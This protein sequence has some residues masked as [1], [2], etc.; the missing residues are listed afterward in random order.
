MTEVIQ[1]WRADGICPK[2][3]AYASDSVMAAHKRCGRCGHYTKKAPDDGPSPLQEIVSRPTV[4][5]DGEGPAEKSV[6]R[7]LLETRNGD[8]EWEE[9]F[10]CGR[11][12]LTD[13]FQEHLE[14]HKFALRHPEA[15]GG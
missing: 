13:T 1:W 15:T 10:V 4:Q 9:C 8:D 7:P 6:S 2:C 5:G 14:A 3:G 11:R 12:V